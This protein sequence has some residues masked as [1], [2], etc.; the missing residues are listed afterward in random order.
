MK[1]LLILGAFFFLT[2]TTMAQS[3]EVVY[4]EKRNLGSQI[5]ANSDPRVKKILAN[6][7]GSESLYM[8]RYSKGKSIYNKTK[9][10]KGTSGAQVMKV[11]GGAYAYFKDQTAKT[12][13]ELNSIYQKEFLIEEPMVVSSWKIEPAADGDPAEIGGYKVMKANGQ[14]GNKEYTVYFTEDIAVNEGP[15]NLWGLPGLILRAEGAG[16]IIEAKSVKWLD[17]QLDIA[18]PADGKFISREDYELMKSEKEADLLSG[19]GGG[20]VITIEKN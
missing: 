5:A 16:K 11:S 2:S 7:A 17:E 12:S 13:I 9:D 3:L 6:L 20:K 18:A 15:R 10:A 14:F 8:L 19:M 1:I 4:G